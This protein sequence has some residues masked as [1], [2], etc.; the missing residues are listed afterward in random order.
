VWGVV[1]LEGWASDDH[2]VRSVQVK[3]DGST[4][5][6]VG[7]S[8][9]DETVEWGYISLLSSIKAPMTV[10]ARAYDGYLFSDVASIVLQVV[11]PP[12]DENLSFGVEFVFPALGQTVGQSLTVKG[13]TFG[14]PVDR[15]YVVMDYDVTLANGTRYW[16]A[17]YIGLKEGF[18]TVRAIAEYHGYFSEWASSFFKVARDIP[19]GN[20]PPTVG[21]LSPTPG[22]IVEGGFNVSGWSQ[23]DGG[24][25]HVEV[26][27]NDGEWVV[28]VGD[29]LW[30]SSVLREQ[31]RAGEN[32]VRCRAYDG[33][34]YS[35]INETRYQYY[36]PVENRAE[37]GEYIWVVVL[38]VAVIVVLSVL[39][40]RKGG[41]H[42]P[43]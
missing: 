11:P 34:L 38:L 2:G 18:H 25:V 33:G 40:V 14:V 37:G 12:V 7:L 21:F 39:L 9:Q 35:D 41:K 43:G 15:V 3:L 30:S 28:A 5:L 24:V 29:Y 13:V 6:D 20:A 4:W 17:S 16:N 22:S 36:P 1:T 42:N 8:E 32:I 26:R 31:L 23:D 27:V 10:Q 19:V